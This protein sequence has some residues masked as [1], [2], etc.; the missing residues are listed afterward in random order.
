M[1]QSREKIIK[2]EQQQ[3][4]SWVGVEETDM[5]DIQELTLI[6]FGDKTWKTIASEEV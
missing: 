2:V 6:K 4:S 5:R 3:D 1:Q